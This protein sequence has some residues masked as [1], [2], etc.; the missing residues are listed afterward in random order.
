[1]DERRPRFPA[2]T[3]RVLFVLRN[4]RFRVLPMVH[5]SKTSTENMRGGCKEGEGW[6]P[7]L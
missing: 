4:A 2:D 6:F 1:M 5:A 7:P 3:A